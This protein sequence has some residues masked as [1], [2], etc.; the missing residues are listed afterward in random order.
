MFYHLKMS[1]KEKLEAFLFVE[2][3]FA[4]SSPSPQSQKNNDDFLDHSIKLAKQ[5]LKIHQGTSCF[6]K[7]LTESFE[8]RDEIWVFILNIF[9][10]YKNEINIVVLPVF[11]YLNFL[12][13]IFFS[14][15][16]S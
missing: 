2:K 3:N 1:C 7:L 13:A 4:A 5:F 10:Y 14:F 11:F 6:A 16:S 9:R 12:L 15:F 8:T